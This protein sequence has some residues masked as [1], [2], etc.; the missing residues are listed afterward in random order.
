M[1]Q[2]R[3]HQKE[4]FLHPS[5]EM[6]STYRNIFNPCDR[7]HF[8]N[9]SKPNF[10]YPQSTTNMNPTLAIPKH[11]LTKIDQGWGQKTKLIHIIMIHIL[12]CTQESY[13]V[14]EIKITL[15]GCA[16]E[17]PRDQATNFYLWSTEKTYYSYI[18]YITYVL[19]TQDFVVRNLWAPH[20][21]SRSQSCSAH[22]S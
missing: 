7:F 21:F 6:C 4:Y 14:W 9:I 12:E 17:A 5:K 11:K 22:W 10:R 20:N 19:G 1:G 15:Q 16:I 13:Q 3:N 2:V 8:A 18:T